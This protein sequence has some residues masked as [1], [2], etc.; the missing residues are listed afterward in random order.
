MQNDYIIWVE[1]KIVIS[2]NE[3]HKLSFTNAGK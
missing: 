2:G 1:S 3:A